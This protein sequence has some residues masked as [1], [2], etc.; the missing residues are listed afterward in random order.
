MLVRGFG[1]SEK[2]FSERLKIHCFDCFVINKPGRVCEEA[3]GDV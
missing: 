3:G 2:R 1:C